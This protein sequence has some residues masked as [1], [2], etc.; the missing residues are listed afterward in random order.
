MGDKKDKKPAAKEVDEEGLLAK[1]KETLTNDKL[2][3]PD[4]DT[5]LRFLVGWG[6]DLNKAL[7]TIRESIKWRAVT[8]PATTQCPECLKD[9]IS[10]CMRVVGLDVQR[11]PVIYTCFGQTRKRDVPETAVTHLCRCLE[12]M[13]VLMRRME[14]DAAE[15][16]KTSEKP[17][18]EAKPEVKKKLSET[19]KGGK[20]VWVV[21]FEDF[22]VSDCSPTQAKLV[23]N[24]LTHYPERLG[25][26]VLLDPPFVFDMVWSAMKPLMPDETL[27]KIKMLSKPSHLKQHAEVFGPELYEWLAAEVKENRESKIAKKKAYW[28]WRDEAGNVKPHDPRGVASFVSSK[29]YTLP[30]D[31]KFCK[32]LQFE[33]KPAAAAAAPP[34]NP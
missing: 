16:A 18:E 11:R 27:A 30:V 4:Q 32:S 5:C 21:D 22:G 17:A 23:G 2:E 24:L 34:A 3:V 15:K 10:H 7:E 26:L 19:V 20:W 28:E 13:I 25:L 6:W 8:K 14:E 12:D 1:F 31:P 9:P 33:Q 29:Y